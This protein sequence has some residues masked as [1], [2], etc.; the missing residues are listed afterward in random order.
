[1]LKKR[2]SGKEFDE[3]REKI[4]VYNKLDLTSL[5]RVISLLVE[6][7]GHFQSYVAS[8]HGDLPHSSGQ[9]VLSQLSACAPIREALLTIKTSAQQ[10]AEK[11]NV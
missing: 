10:K 8:Y 7:I 1:M 3:L 6:I 4:Y 2:Y 9:E 5:R 11:R